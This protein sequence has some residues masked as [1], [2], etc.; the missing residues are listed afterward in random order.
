MSFFSLIEPALAALG[1]T[2]NELQIA[3]AEALASRYYPNLSTDRPALIGPLTDDRLCHKLGHLLRLAYPP[4]HLVTV[5]ASLESGAFDMQSSSL[6]RLEHVTLGEGIAL[7]YLPPLP[8]AGAVETFQD[9]IA[10]L[11]APDGC[12]W[13]RRQTHRSLRQA[14]QEEA[15]EVLDAL[16]QGDMEKL[17]EEL[18]DV[19]LHVLMQAYM[20]SEADEFRMSDVVHDVNAKIVRRHPHVF[21]DLAVSG[22]NQVL[23]NW[24]EIKRQEKGLSRSVLDSVS[25]AMPALA[26]AQSIQRHVEPA[27][28]EGVAERGVLATRIAEQLSALLQAPDAAARETRLGDLLFELADWARKLGIDAE[29]ALRDANAR[30]ERRFRAWEARATD[31]S[32]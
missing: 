2:P 7:L 23:A 24:E 17:K 9:T 18:G 21:G 13:D 4:A 25:L 20:A 11:R 29:S 26:W 1:L 10:H 27:W 22:V 16:D 30:F 31:R 15:Y 8:Y 6:D 5:V 14:F 19:L 12:P 3:D 32:S 28:D